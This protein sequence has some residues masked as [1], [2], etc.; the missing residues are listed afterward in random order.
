MK[1]PTIP[2]TRTRWIAAAAVLAVL[3]VSG[4]GYGV[5]VVRSDNDTPAVAAPSSTTTSTST[6]STTVT[7]TTTID[8]GGLQSGA[9]G[10]AVQAVQQ[11]LLDLHFDP[12]AADGKFGLATTYA[13]QAFEKLHGMP[14]DGKVD[15]AFL[16][17]L[18]NP[19]PIV[20]LAPDGGA[21]R[22]EVDL[23]HQVLAVYLDN[24][25]RLI[26]HVSTGNNQRYCVEGDCQVAVTPVGAFR[27]S[28]RATG[29][30]EARLGKLYN[31][32]Y[33]TS[34]GVAVHGS[35]SV[36]TYPASHGCVR[37]PM[38]IAEYFPSLVKRGDPIFVSDGRPVGPPPA[39]PSSPPT[40][41]KPATSGDST[42]TTS[43]TAQPTTTTAPPP[44][45]T[46]APP[47][48]STPT[49]LTSTTNP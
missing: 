10:P 17:A 8:P 7:T 37:I 43:T 22:V 25:L 24:N 21:N 30:R 2:M 46:T 39:L 41:D 12:G 29:W 20:A 45:T 14:P 44:T 32:I 3:A 19:A 35:L 15:A 16:A 47:T 6:T 34:D 1:L 5:A 9:E 4:I 48:S 11:R 36:P 23:A 31:P 27:F 38:H 42:T 13:V 40:T 26:T 49:T 33:F 18:A 28:W